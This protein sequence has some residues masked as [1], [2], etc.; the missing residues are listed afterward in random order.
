V[1]VDMR[2]LARVKQRKQSG[3]VES[4]APKTKAAE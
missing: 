2:E 1:A 3:E 4:P